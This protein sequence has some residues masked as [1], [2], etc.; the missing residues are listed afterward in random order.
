[1]GLNQAG[2]VTGV[3]GAVRTAVS[4]IATSMYS[5]ILTTEAMKYLPQ[6]VIPAAVSAGLP[7]S[8]L[9]ALFEAVQN[10]NLTVVPGMSQKIMAAVDAAVKDAYARS[11]QTVYLCTLPFGALL[12]ISALFS[13]NVEQYLTDEV[14]RK[15]HPTA[16]AKTDEEVTVGHV[17]KD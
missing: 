6:K 17:G 16:T 14:A 1:M 13:P 15:L 3:L 4:A 2:L 10:G 5:S 9:P 7:S 11:Y 12:V 8:S